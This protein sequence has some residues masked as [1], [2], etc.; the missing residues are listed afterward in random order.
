M[1]TNEGV[2]YCK[3]FPLLSGEK[4]KKSQVIVPVLVPHARS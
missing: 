2:G 3:L 4:K 1:T